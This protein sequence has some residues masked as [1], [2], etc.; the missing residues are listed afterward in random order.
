MER[1]THS[2]KGRNGV[3]DSL[4]LIYRIRDAAFMRWRSGEAFANPTPK[5]Q[6]SNRGKG[7]LMTGVDLNLRVTQTIDLSDWCVKEF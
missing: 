6:C 7:L 1:M 4:Q 5:V 2:V 3:D